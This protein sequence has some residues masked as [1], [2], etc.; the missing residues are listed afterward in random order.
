VNLFANYINPNQNAFLQSAEVGV[1]GTVSPNVALTDAY[2]QANFRLN[3]NT[4]LDSKINFNVP[5]NDLSASLGAAYSNSTTK[6]DGRVNVSSQ[7]GVEVVGSGSTQLRP[8]E[9]L[10][11]DLR[12]AN[13]GVNTVGVKLDGQNTDASLR[14]NANTDNNNREVLGT[15]DT[16]INPTTTIA[17]DVRVGNNGVNTV[18]VKLDG[19]NT[20]ASLR[21][22]A[23]TDNNN[24][25]VL[26]TVDTRINPTTTIAGDVRVGNNGVNTVGVKLDGQNTD[27][28][29]R[30]NADTQ[31]NNTEVIGSVTSQ[32][33]PTQTLTGN[34]RVGTGADTGS[35]QFTEN[36]NQFN[37]FTVGGNFNTGSE[38]TPGSANLNGEYRFGDQQ[39]NR[40]RR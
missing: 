9:T 19:Q 32:L 7:N 25:E 18:G 34:V 23:N 29:L 33:S 5:N 15:V 21:F 17:G 27:A 16:R 2:G 28:S 38:T 13:T 14:F 26:G 11:G 20:D 12:V 10:S 36:R 31:T 4:T 3:P 22:N 39:L 1:K 40:H 30:V 8:G 37:G 35:I 6:L 24:R